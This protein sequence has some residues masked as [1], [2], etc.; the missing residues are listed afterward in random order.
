MRKAQDLPPQN[1]ASLRRRSSGRRPDRSKDEAILRAAGLSFLERGFFGSS[2]EDIAARAGVSRVT[3]SKRFTD[4]AAL[5]QETV[6]AETADA[7]RALDYELLTN[8][9]LAERLNALGL[10]LMRRMLSPRQLLLDRM[11]RRDLAQVP[12]LAWRFFESARG[13]C[14]DLLAAAAAGEIEID[15]LLL[16]ATDLLGLWRGLLEEELVFGVREGV[17]EEDLRRRVERGTQ[18]FLKMTR[19]VV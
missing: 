2:I 9:P 7:V 11:L 14:R 16:A 17:D 13:H 4:K 19:P 6:R 18:L 10:V 12:E 8:E 1:K 5:F 15:D 3:V